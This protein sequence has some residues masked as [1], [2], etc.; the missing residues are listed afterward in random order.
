MGSNYENAEGEKS[1]KSAVNTDMHQ[2]YLNQSDNLASV[3]QFVTPTNSYYKYQVGLGNN[4]QLIRSLLRQRICFHHINRDKNLPQCAVQKLDFDEA[5]IMW[6]QWRKLK[7]FAYMTTFKSF[8]SEFKDLLKF[9]SEGK[10]AVAPPIVVNDKSEK[11]TERERPNEKIIKIYTNG[12][13]QSPQK[14]KDLNIKYLKKIKPTDLKNK[15]HAKKNSKG[16]FLDSEV[17]SKMQKT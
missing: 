14:S 5:Q 12:G 13:S 1:K 3:G 4:H 6:S 11:K 10:I 16:G 15:S 2:E 8:Q 17:T 9:I 7:L